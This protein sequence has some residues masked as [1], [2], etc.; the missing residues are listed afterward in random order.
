MIKGFRGVVLEGA[1]LGAT[2]RPAAVVL[3]MTIGVAVAAV[4]RFRFTD[5]KVWED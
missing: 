2:L 4:W 1:S 5:E 3:A